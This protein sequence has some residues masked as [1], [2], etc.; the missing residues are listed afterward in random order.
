MAEEQQER[1][2]VSELIEELT[3]RSN[4]LREEL[5]VME[6][7]FNTKKEEFVKL[8]GAL[9]AFNYVKGPDIVV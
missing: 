1:K 5:M 7:E 4:T 6:R 3:E 2:S 8:Q 9:E